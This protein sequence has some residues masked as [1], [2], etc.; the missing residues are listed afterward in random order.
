[1]ALFA[2]AAASQSSACGSLIHFDR[3]RRAGNPTDIAMSAPMQ[4]Y[5]DN[6]Q[7]QLT[8]QDFPPSAENDCSIRAELAE[9]SVHM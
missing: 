2:A 4:R 5:R 9:T 7:I 3:W 8:S 1:M 6:S